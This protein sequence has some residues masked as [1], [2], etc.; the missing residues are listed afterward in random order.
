MNLQEKHDSKLQLVQN[1]EARMILNLPKF[2]TI[3]PGLRKLHWLP[4]HTQVKFKALCFAH[5][6][7]Y[8]TGPE[9]LRHALRWYI[10]NRLLR[11]A[12]SNTLVIS[13]IRQANWG[14]RSFIVSTT[15][16]W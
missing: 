1:T 6:G 9:F 16:L 7:L 13:R 3:S 10:P 14:G 5:K 15:K 2:Q 12:S 4:V 8:H 11:S